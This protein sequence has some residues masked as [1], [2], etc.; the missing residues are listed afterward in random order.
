MKT[1]VGFANFCGRAFLTLSLLVVV[2][3]PAFAYDDPP[4]RVARLNYLEGRV[5]F[6]PGGETDWAWATVNRPMTAGDSLWTGNGSRA[7]MHIGSTAIRMSGQTSVSFLNL[8]D[9]TVQIQLNSETIRCARAQSLRRQRLPI[10]V[11]HSSPQKL[12]VVRRP[13]LGRFGIRAW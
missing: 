6:Q 9:R 8:D 1:T 12:L 4:I 7:E 11:P 13:G 2:A 3:R 10:P 5:S